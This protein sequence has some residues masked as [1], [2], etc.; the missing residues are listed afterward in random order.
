M[1]AHKPPCSNADDIG[2]QS[3]IELVTRAN[4][5]TKTRRFAQAVACY[6]SLVRLQPQNPR[7]RVQLGLAL[8]EFGDRQQAIAALEDALSFGRRCPKA[9]LGFSKVLER[10]GQ[11]ALALLACLLVLRFAPAYP[12]LFPRLT[13]LA[14]RA[15]RNVIRTR[16]DRAREMLYRALAPKARN[17][18][19]GRGIELTRREPDAPPQRGDLAVLGKIWLAMNRIGLDA[20]A[21]ER[22]PLPCD[23]RPDEVLQYFTSS[24]NYRIISLSHLDEADRMFLQRAGLHPEHLKSNQA[25][26]IQEDGQNDH[27]EFAS[28]LPTPVATVFRDTRFQL[29]LARHGT[30]RAICPGTGCI[31]SSDRSFAMEPAHGCGAVFYRFSGSQVFYVLV[32]NV[33]SGFSKACLYFP[34]SDLIVVLQ[35]LPWE[36]SEFD[37]LKAFV[38]AHQRKVV[39]YLRRDVE[40]RRAVLIDCPHFAHHLWNELPGICKLMDA[41]LLGSIDAFF[42][43]TE[44][45]APLESIFPEIPSSK[46]QR[47]S[48]SDLRAAALDGNYVVMRTGLNFISEDLATRVHRA[49]LQLCSSAFRERLHRVRSKHFPLL[50]VSIRL[51]H[52]TWVSQVDGVA[53]IVSLLARTFP[54]LGVVFDGFSR[55]SDRPALLSANGGW[56]DS[57]IQEEQH[58][59]DK[60]RSLVAPGVAIYD[61]IGAM[62]FESIAWA[63]TIDL[64][65]THHGSIQHKVAWTGNRPG[66]VH[67]NH[68]ASLYAW[69][70]TFWA[71]ENAVAPVY[72]PRRFVTNVGGSGDQ[73]APDARVDLDNYECDWEGVYSEV[74]TL[75]QMLESPDWRAVG[76]GLPNR[77]ARRR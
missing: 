14:F 52:R 31:L 57:I 71:R 36:R 34:A 47:V 62:L 18:R 23:L 55:P 26:L 53:K 73:A 46:I 43:V 74:L 16:V 56:P 11:V 48:R 6:R 4:A 40:P 29:H 72:V 51:H 9:L 32:T 21:L 58:T 13:R 60:I 12:E 39:S 25:S 2:Q 65:L 19:D 49:A 45:I 27:G 1:T 44:P 30:L 76:T 41:G 28:D 24:S 66:V 22:L 17:P 3:E 5:F 54:R 38:T 8:L 77:G 63:H 67:T 42:I 69:H 35:Q 70:Q 64:Y 20:A 59:L 37:Q 7:L 15:A 61:A 33:G 10:H 50:W 68:V 75:A